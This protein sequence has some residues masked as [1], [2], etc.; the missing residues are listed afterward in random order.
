MHSNA[1]PLCINK[2]ELFSYNSKIIT[3]F[4]R[5]VQN[6]AFNDIIIIKKEK[7]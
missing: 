7:D 3:R 6:F 2:N 5:S 4:S 1:Y